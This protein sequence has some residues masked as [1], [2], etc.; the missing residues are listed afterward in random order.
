MCGRF[1]QV[2]SHVIL[3]M[4]YRLEVKGDFVPRYNLA[5]SQHAWV[6]RT[7]PLN[8]D[9]EILLLKWGLVPPWIKDEARVSKPINARVETVGQNPFFRNA[10]QRRRALIPAN[11]YYEWKKVNGK[12]Q[13]YLI[14]RKDERPFSMAGLWER[15][16]NERNT[17]GTFTIITTAAIAPVKAIHHRMPLI[18][19]EEIY[20]R[21]L[22]PDTPP[23]EL[24]DLIH[25]FPATGLITYP[26]SPLVNKPSND[27]PEC[28]RPLE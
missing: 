27:S 13:P 23:G 16:E 11:G 21:W 26:V 15:R 10:F 25:P 6:L 7:N 14:R 24:Q 22:D 4:L 3:N 1:V 9:R 19:S 2:L 12:K 8:G 17:H 5:P 18:L 20:N 28:I